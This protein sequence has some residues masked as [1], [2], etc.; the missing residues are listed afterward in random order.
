MP[1]LNQL[2]AV[3][4]T[5][6][7]RAKSLKTQAYHLFQKPELFNGH[8]K[9]YAPL[10]EEGE[11]LPPQPKKVQQTVDSLIESVRGA[12]EEML[13]V[14]S[15]Q[16][17]GNSVATADVV[18][19]DQLVAQNVPVTTLLFLEKELT[20]LQAFVDAVP[21][22]DT[23]EQ[24]DKDNNLGLYV[25][26]PS[27]TVRTNKEKRPIVLYDAT[28][29]HPAQT[30]LVDVDVSVGTWTTTRLSGALSVPDKE[31]LV[32]RVRKLKE[33]VVQAREEANSKEVDN[34]T[35]GNKVLKYIFE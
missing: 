19:D 2:I 28:P 17:V 26:K 34:V 4:Q 30:Q 5:K 29:N 23:S 31:N 8:E 13:D 32:K 22:L 9:T 15:S 7:Q 18:V 20:D 12:V 10:N 35:L 21:T 11:R 1:R 24:W 6:K 14:V 16:D 25:A 27:K 33:A 3:S